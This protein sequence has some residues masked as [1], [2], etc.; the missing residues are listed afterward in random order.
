MEKII[1]VI[2]CK[3]DKGKLVI[4]GKTDGRRYVPLTFFS[5]QNAIE[6]RIKYNPYKMKF[7]SYRKA[8]VEM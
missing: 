6:W 3:N 8:T 2:V 7:Y 1:W 5:R 4:K